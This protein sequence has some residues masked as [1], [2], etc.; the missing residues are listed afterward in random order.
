MQKNQLN[1]NTTSEPLWIP[2]RLN[3]VHPEIIKVVNSII[4]KIPDLPLSFNRILEK[5][6]DEDSSLEELVELVS[7]DPMLVSN[8]LKVVNSS[9][10][11]LR[12]KTRVK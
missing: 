12:H 5:I 1:N 3:D 10:Y 11:G 4:E 7:S 2:M 9:Y 6:T 8:I